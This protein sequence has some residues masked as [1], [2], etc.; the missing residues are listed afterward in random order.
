MG[1]S[2]NRG[3]QKMDAHV[4]NGKPYQTGWFGGTTIFRNIHIFLGATRFAKNCLLHALNACHSSSAL[5]RTCS[6]KNNVT[7]TCD[8]GHVFKCTELWRGTNDESTHR[9]H[10]WYIHRI[11]NHKNQRNPWIGKYTKLVPCIQK[12]VPYA[13]KLRINRPKTLKSNQHHEFHSISHQ[14]LGK[15]NTIR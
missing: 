13:L 5:S 12:R 7:H 10:V 1:V 14:L 9:I 4:Y 8:K 6:W 3:T 11:E 2:K 15:N